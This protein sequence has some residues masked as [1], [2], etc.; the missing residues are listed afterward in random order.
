MMNSRSREH[1][2][3]APLVGI[4][5]FVSTTVERRERIGLYALA[6]RI[7]MKGSC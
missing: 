1:A 3:R 7:L 5:L 4:G 2:W 6:N